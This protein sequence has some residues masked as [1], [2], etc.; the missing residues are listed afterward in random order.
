MARPW[1]LTYG[2]QIRAG[3]S[4]T[5]NNEGSNKRTKGTVRLP[6]LRDGLHG[7]SANKIRTKNKQNAHFKLNHTSVTPMH[8]TT[9]ETKTCVC[10]V[11]SSRGH[12]THPLLSR[13]DPLTSRPDLSIFS[14]LSTFLPSLASMSLVCCSS[15]SRSICP[16][17]AMD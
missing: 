14:T 9:D 8:D 12:R 11:E 2:V 1:H 17:R 16:H 13:V 5:I 7:S 4:R 6:K 15:S 3:K 10:P